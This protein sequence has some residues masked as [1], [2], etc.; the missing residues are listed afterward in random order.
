MLRSTLLNETVQHKHVGM[1]TKI[2]SP[3][4]LGKLPS[5][6]GGSS[7]TTYKEL[8]SLAS[9]MNQPEMIYQ[10]MHLSNNSSLWTD[11]VGAAFGVGHLVKSAGKELEPYLSSIIPRIY[12]LV[13]SLVRI[14]TYL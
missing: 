13:L 3:E 4:D 7:L 12:R 1:D 11:R 14:H 6:M 2:F 10:F 8:C 9:D 5:S